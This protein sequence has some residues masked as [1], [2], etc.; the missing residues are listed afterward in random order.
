I[1]CTD[2]RRRSIE[3]WRKQTGEEDQNRC[4]G[5]NRITIGEGTKTNG[6]GTRFCGN[7]QRK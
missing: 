3:M 5:V 2:R 6:E 1:A 7:R 4:G